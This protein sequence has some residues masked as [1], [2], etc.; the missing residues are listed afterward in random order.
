MSRRH[1]DTWTMK[2]PI[3]ATVFV[4]A[5]IVTVVLAAFTFLLASTWINPFQGIMGGGFGGLGGRVVED[6]PVAPPPDAPIVDP[7][8]IA[9]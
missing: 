9:P 1:E 4:G 7:G 5:L 2:F 6:F 3:E 8:F